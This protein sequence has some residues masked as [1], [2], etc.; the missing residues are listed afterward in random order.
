[1]KILVISHEYPPIG[2][3]GGRVAQ[4]ICI[5]LAQQGNEIRIITAHYGALPVLEEQNG[6]LIQR[7]I[8]GRAEPYRAGVKAMGLFTIAGGIAAFRMIRKWR[9]DL[10]QIHF[11]LPA[12]LIGLLMNRLTGI[13]YIL[14]AHLG[15]VPGGVPEKTDRWFRW[16][17]PFTPPIWKH[18]ASVIAV[19]EFTRQLALNHYPVEIKVIPN[20]VDLQALDP[21]EILTGSPPV[22]VFAGRFV[23]QKNLIQLVH[24]LHDVN[25]LSWSCILLGDGPTRQEVENEI[26]RFNLSQRISMPG[27]INPSEVIEIFK[28]CD[29]L[30]MPSLS[31]GLP[32]VGV[33]ALSMGLAIIASKVGGLVDVVDHGINGYLID[34]SN[35]EGFT[36]ALIELLSDQNKLLAFRQASRLKASQF[37]IHSVADA[38]FDLYQTCIKEKLIIIRN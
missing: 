34:Q 10:I 25:Y 5:E 36:R 16:A 35:P 4:D 21:G 13:P 1:M 26:N 2:G 18:A 23:Q 28:R 17:Q 12:G 9:P 30:F 15:D 22:I 8:S 19:S 14:T 29:L 11:A 38:Y 6:F 31:E 32:V 27:W 37:D 24:S 33:Q 7:V 20:G 3:G